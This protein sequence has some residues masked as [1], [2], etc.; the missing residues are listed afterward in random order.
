MKKIIF[1]LLILLSLF[2]LTGCIENKNPDKEPDTGDKGKTDN[3]DDGEEDM[4]K[5]PVDLTIFTEILPFFS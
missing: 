1:S 2:L 3:P 5:D 4:D